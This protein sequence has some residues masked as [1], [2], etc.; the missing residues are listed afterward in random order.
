MIGPARP[1]EAEPLGARSAALEGPLGLPRC[2]HVS[3]S[4]GAHGDPGAGGVRRRHRAGLRRHL[5]AKARRLERAKVSVASDPNAEAFYRAMGATTV[6]TA[7][8]GSIPGHRLPR[9]ELAL[10]EGM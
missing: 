7:P 8:S 3:L 1:G 2:L 5:V 9:M 4:G 10:G 6:G